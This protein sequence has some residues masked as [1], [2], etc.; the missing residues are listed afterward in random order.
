MMINNLRT[1]FRLPVAIVLKRDFEEKKNLYAKNFTL[2]LIND[3]APVIHMIRTFQ[4]IVTGY[5]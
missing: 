1:K 4:L 5:S 3:P 2:Y